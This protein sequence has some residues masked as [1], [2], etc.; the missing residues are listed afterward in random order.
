MR[1]VVID[2]N[3]WVSGVRYPDSVPGRIVDF[4]RVGRIQPVLSIELIDQ[5]LRA[6][7]R[8]GTAVDAVHTVESELR[9]FSDVVAPMQR[10][11]VIIAKESDNRVLECAVAGNADAIV[12]G[13]RKH[14]LRLGSYEGIPII[15]LREFVDT[16]S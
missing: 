14:L 6:L 5:V 8:L 13:D 9:R 1:R 7:L 2:A 3:V 4:A 16:F 15:S 12:T 11:A 10:L